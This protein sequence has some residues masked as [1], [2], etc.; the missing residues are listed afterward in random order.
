MVQTAK[1]LRNIEVI[2]LIRRL[3]TCADESPVLLHR[4]RETLD[5]APAPDYTT[6]RMIKL[7]GIRPLLK[8]LSV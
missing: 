5:A 7:F 3:A 2:V 4:H 1:V 6:K 8:A